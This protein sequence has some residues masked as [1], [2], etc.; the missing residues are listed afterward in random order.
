MAR[1]DKWLLRKAPG[2]RRRHLHDNGRYAFDRNKK[3][4]VM[5]K[6]F[7]HKRGFGAP[8]PA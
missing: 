2:S 8:A 5:V 1:A 7:P 3:N 6:K 4:L